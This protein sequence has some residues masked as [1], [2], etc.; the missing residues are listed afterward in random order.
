MHWLKLIYAEEDLQTPYNNR[1]H[2]RDKAMKY[3]LSSTS[4]SLPQGKRKKAQDDDGH[5]DLIREAAKLEGIR[6]QRSP[7]GIATLA[8][9]SATSTSDLHQRHFSTVN[10]QF[11]EDKARIFTKSCTRQKE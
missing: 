8:S 6:Q 4:G 7:N 5:S 9:K 10:H 3:L 2:V 1:D 11:Q